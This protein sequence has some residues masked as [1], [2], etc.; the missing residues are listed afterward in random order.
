MLGACGI[1][2][3]TSDVAKELGFKLI[4]P[5]EK[6]TSDTLPLS[7]VKTA[8][9]MS[10]DGEMKG[11]RNVWTGPSHGNNNE[12]KLSEDF[13]MYPARFRF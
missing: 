7:L 3:L 10:K 6:Y 13:V 11:T 8:L 12:Y 1:K 5:G 4:K 2:C 9:V